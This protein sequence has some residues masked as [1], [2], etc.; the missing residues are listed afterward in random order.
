MDAIAVTPVCAH[1]L[2]AALIVFSASSAPRRGTSRRGLRRCACPLDGSEMF[3]VGYGES[4]RITKSPLSC[5]FVRLK[6]GGFYEVLRRKMAES[7]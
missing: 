2:S 5:G 1:S 6:D 3:R 7:I 4:V